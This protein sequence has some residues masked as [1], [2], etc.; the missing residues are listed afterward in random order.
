LRIIFQTTSS[1]TSKEPSPE[2]L[3]RCPLKLSEKAQAEEKMSADVGQ[4]E[5][6]ATAAPREAAAE[7]SDNEDDI[8]FEVDEVCPYFDQILYPP[9]PFVEYGYYFAS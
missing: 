7:K 3:L 4:E 8:R 5:E 6:A 1:V 2:P 9:P